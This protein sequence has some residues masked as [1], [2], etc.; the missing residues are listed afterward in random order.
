VSPT[1]LIIRMVI[2]TVALIGAIL[3]APSWFG[4]EWG[5]SE[6]VALARRLL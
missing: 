1:D 5:L 6:W 3:V 4:F 2:V